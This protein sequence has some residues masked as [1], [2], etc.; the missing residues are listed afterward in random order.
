MNSEIILMA[1]FLQWFSTHFLS[2]SLGQASAATVTAKPA[3]LPLYFWLAR[4]PISA[5]SPIFRWF[6]KSSWFECD[7]CFLLGTWL[8]EFSSIS[9]IAYSIDKIQS[10]WGW[11]FL[12]CVSL[13]YFFTTLYSHKFCSPLGSCVCAR[14]T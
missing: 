4:T 14:L 3:L 12:F 10:Q 1:L 9:I 6:V 13:F 5:N 7:I 2:W 8:I 11:L